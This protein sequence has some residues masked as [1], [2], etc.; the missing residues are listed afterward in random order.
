VTPLGLAVVALVLADLTFAVDSIS[1]AF[2]IT[3]DSV[4]I[5]LANALALLGLV[6]LLVLVRA[7][8]QRFRYMSQTSAA[9]P[10]FIA[11]RLLTGDVVSLGP[12]VSLAAIVAILCAGLLASQ[13]ADILVN[14]AC[15]MLLAP[16]GFQRSEERRR[17]VETNLMGAMTATGISLEQL[18][19]GG[20]DIVNISLGCATRSGQP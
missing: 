17:V 8:V 19:A 6:P 12:L 18:R 10:L 4:V 11:L 1:G 9:V 20:G 2:G 16:F 15:V 5:W 14:I 3:T 7:L 13:A